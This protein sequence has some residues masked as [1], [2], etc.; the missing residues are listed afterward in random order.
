LLAT[1]TLDGTVQLWEVKTGHD[2]V[3]LVPAKRRTFEH[4]IGQAKTVAFSPD[5]KTIAAAGYYDHAIH[6]WDTTT[7][8]ERRRWTGPP[9]VVWT[10]AFSPDGSLLGAT[11]GFADREIRLLD[12]STGKAAHT[13][14]GHKGG[15]LQVAFS[16]SGSTLA[17]ASNDETLRIW[18]VAS[19]SEVA[20]FRVPKAVFLSISFSTDGRVLASADLVSGEIC[21]WELLTGSPRLRFHLE[22][23]SVS[24]IAFVPHT[25][26]LASAQTDGAVI[27]WDTTGRKLR[28]DPRHRGLTR[29]ELETL[30][31]ELG[32]AD[33]ERAYRAMIVLAGRPREALPFLESRIRPVVAA[34]GNVLRKLIAELDSRDFKRRQRATKDLR[35]LG[36]TAEPALREALKRGDHAEVQASVERLLQEI[37]TSKK[38]PEGDDLARRRGVEAMER[39]ATTAARR[40]LDIVARGSS[41]SALTRDAGE[42]CRRLHSEGSGGK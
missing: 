34:D 18:D 4:A 33:A 26:K 19:G 25:D 39:M 22:P 16:P 9:G 21:L 3:S 14:S 37:A 10:I 32:G 7:C 36:E 38:K 31:T 41:T 28:E 13:L 5:G 6:E 12:R 42:A 35:R 40:V 23:E 30:W 8:V 20:R 1:G 27:L 2:R 17:S 15:V 29:A 11:G 24:Q